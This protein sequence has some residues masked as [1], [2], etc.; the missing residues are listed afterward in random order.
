MML[1]RGNEKGNG[2][3]SARPFVRSPRAGR[4]AGDDRCDL[5]W[6]RG[7][8]WARTLRRIAA[9]FGCF[10]GCIPWSWVAGASC[11]ALAFAGLRTTHLDRSSKYVPNAHS[12]DLP[13]AG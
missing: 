1:R 11:P 13:H 9:A 2:G 6:C 8:A 12:E 4:R 3:R 10:P 5:S 7:R